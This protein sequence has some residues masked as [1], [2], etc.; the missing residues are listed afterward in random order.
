MLTRFILL[1]GLAVFA[2]VPA[3]AQLVAPTVSNTGSDNVVSG[4]D[5]IDLNT[6]PP[7]RAGSNLTGSATSDAGYGI[8]G[9]ADT[10]AA[11]APH[12]GVE[13]NARANAP[14]TTAVAVPR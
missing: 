1:A 10:T 12:H 4:R 6:V 5:L 9:V 14:R 11:P 2:G 8:A 3:A 7:A 13:L